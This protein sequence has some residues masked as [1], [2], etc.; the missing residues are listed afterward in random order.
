MRQSPFSACDLVLL[1]EG[2]LFHRVKVTQDAQTG[3]I[4]VAEPCI[5]CSLGLTKQLEVLREHL[6]PAKA[7]I[8][9]QEYTVSLFRQDVQCF[10]F[11]FHPNSLLASNYRNVFYIE[12][13]DLTQLD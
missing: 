5:D 13:S 2:S 7:T 4:T 6:K 12:R 10:D 3:L 8:D 11:G 1:T 9:D